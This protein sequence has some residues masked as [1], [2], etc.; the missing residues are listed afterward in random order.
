MRVLVD[1]PEAG[2]DPAA[3][4][5][6]TGA[7][8][9]VV[10]ESHV[11]IPT[12]TAA[13]GALRVLV[14]GR[15][16][17]RAA[18]AG[19]LPPLDS[20]GRLDEAG[21][22]LRLWEERGP[23]L[24]PAL[25]GAFALAI[26]DGRTRRLVLARDQLGL[27][28]LYLTGERG[29]LAASPSLPALLALPGVSRVW[30]AGALDALLTLGAVP[31]PATPYLAVRQLA[32]GELLMLEDGRSRVQRWW[33]LS[34]PD[35]A[36]VRG[37]GTAAVRERLREAVRMRTGGVR[38]TLCLSGGLDAV[39]LL[40]LATAVHRTPPRALTWTAL[41]DAA[42][43][44]RLAARAIGRAALEHAL[45]EEPPDWAA[46]P[47][48]LLDVHGVPVP[49]FDLAYLA[50]V[51]RPDVR[52][53]TGHGGEAIVGG[54]APHREWVALSRFR[55]LPGPLR[56]LAQLWGRLRPAGEVQQL[57]TGASL[58]AL[59]CLQRAVRRLAPAPRPEL[60]T[61]EALA[62]LGGRGGDDLLGALA[63]EAVVA[64]ADDP[65]DV[66]HHVH[67]HLALPALAALHLE[68][69]VRG[70]EL[71]L[72]LVDHRV[73]Q[74]VLGVPPER[75]GGALTRQLLLRATLGR[76]LPRGLTRQ[77]ARRPAPSATAWA[78][79]PL[80]GLLE[81]TLS[82]ERV[83]AQGVFRPETL[84]RLVAEHRAGRADHGHAL[85]SLVLVSRW[86]ERAGWPSAAHAR[87]SA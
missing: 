87:A 16:Y 10:F 28:P 40:G 59:G 72:P 86:L 68:A 38:T 51:A 36:A 83:A 33:Q 77:A 63:G 80:R 23:G 48:A 71:R 37:D 43:E 47:A 84:A 15:F 6:T 42:I 46:V 61:V 73:A 85:W 45:V 29:R 7:G 49:G 13:G 75:R 78:R 58:A 17:N 19:T 31:P 35:R 21:V 56:E 39:A 54:G 34:V 8:A 65:L 76:Q 25:R 79:E 22:V 69:A 5:G 12:S 27:V 1:W 4:V 62:A 82:S 64:G 20:G 81:D 2:A 60:Y 52:L 70:A 14:A 50:T 66:I 67:L 30:D 26:W 32:P 74:V 41:R 57:V 11:R 3:R 55:A 53:L 9:A 44:G 18:L 24:L